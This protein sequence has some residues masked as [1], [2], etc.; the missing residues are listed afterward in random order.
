MGADS[1][2]VLLYIPPRPPSYPSPPPKAPSP[3]ISESGY[4]SERPSTVPV[5]KKNMSLCSTQGTK[6]SHL[7]RILEDPDETN[8]TK[9]QLALELVKYDTDGDGWVSTGEMLEAIVEVVDRLKMNVS[10]LD[11]IAENRGAIGKKV[12][13]KLHE[14]DKDGDGAIDADE[15]VDA[16]E[17]LVKEEESGKFWFRFSMVSCLLT[18]ITIV[19]IVGLSVALQVALKDTKVDATS[20]TLTAYR[21]SGQNQALRVASSD[22]SVSSSGDFVPRN[23]SGLVNVATK[24]STVTDCPTSF[25]SEYLRHIEVI[26]LGLDSDQTLYL[27]PSG[28]ILGSNQVT[29]FTQLGNVTFSNK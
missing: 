19:V 21:G 24:L 15:L 23:S 29:F 1:E 16:M 2:N 14:K 17:E 26:E 20:N 27:K 13:R 25:D 7:R 9:K 3:K 10:D 4:Y 11:R 22:F 18:I 12:A 6:V 28:F 5:L 8:L